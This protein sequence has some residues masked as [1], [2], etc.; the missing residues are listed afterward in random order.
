MHRLAWFAIIVGADLEAA[1]NARRRARL[2]P[3]GYGVGGSLQRAA[4]SLSPRIWRDRIRASSRVR[5][6]Q[7]LAPQEAL[8]LLVGRAPPAAKWSTQSRAPV[9]DRSPTTPTVNVARA[10]Q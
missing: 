10:V 6:R 9:P 2:Q 3:A 8:G 1:A 5:E 4:V 7:A